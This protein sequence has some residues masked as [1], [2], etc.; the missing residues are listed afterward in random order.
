[1]TL[2]R[3]FARSHR[4]P[5]PSHPNVST[6]DFRRRPEQ[7]RPT[8]KSSVSAPLFD[9][10]PSISPA[11]WRSLPICPRSEIRS[12]L[13]DSYRKVE[14][15][16]FSSHPSRM[17]SGMSDTAL[18]TQRTDASIIFICGATRLLSD[19][20][21]EATSKLNPVWPSRQV[22]VTSSSRGFL[23]KLKWIL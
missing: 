17:V 19:V 6:N 16:L 9:A 4:V 8:L 22:L 12:A 10:L 13:P 7:V 20:M 3:R 5:N 11:H 14:P 1:M 21:V 23:I 2:T 18:P 15:D